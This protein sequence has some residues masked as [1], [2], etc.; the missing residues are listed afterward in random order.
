MKKIK[1]SLQ[2]NKEIIT[3]LESANVQGG[4]GLIP[5]SGL[6][7]CITADTICNCLDTHSMK[8][9]VIVTRDASCT[10]PPPPGSSLC[11][12]FK[13]NTIEGCII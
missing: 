8:P 7:V 13:Y 9:C 11:E 6:D 3:R 10:C 5:L 2:L 1:K 4:G 12:D